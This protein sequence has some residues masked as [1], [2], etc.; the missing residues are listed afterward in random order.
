MAAKLISI[1]HIVAVLWLGLLLAAMLVMVRMFFGGIVIVACAVLLCRTLAALWAGATS[2]HELS[3]RPLAHC[4]SGPPKA[5]GPEQNGD[6][7]LNP[8]ME[9]S[10]AA[11]RRR[12]MGRR[13]VDENSDQNVNRNEQTGRAE[14]SS[15]ETHIGSLTS[16]NTEADAHVEAGADVGADAIR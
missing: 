14:K 3:G 6:R 1:G 10:K 13:G 16:A 12:Q 2:C 5:Q 11:R 9:R 8:A 7:V 15:Y 4:E